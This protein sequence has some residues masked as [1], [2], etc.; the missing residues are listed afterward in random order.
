MTKKKQT[1]IRPELLDELLQG[2]SV[3]NIFKP[4]KKSVEQ[5]Q[6]ER[7]LRKRS[8]AFARFTLRRFSSMHHSDGLKNV[9]N[10]THSP[11]CSYFRDSQP[12]FTTLVPAPLPRVSDITPII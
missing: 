3:A 6:Q 8:T 1:T 12:T 7:F 9:C 2:G 4:I 11:P 5:Q 10:T